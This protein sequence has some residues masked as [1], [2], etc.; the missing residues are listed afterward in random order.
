MLENKHKNSIFLDLD[1]TLICGEPS[2]ELDFNL[3]KNKHKLFDSFDMDGYYMIYS[4]PYLQEFLDYIFSNFNV[5]IWT[6]AS[7]DYALFIIEK[8]ILH[9]KPDRHLDFIFFDYHCNLSKKINNYTKKLSILWDHYKLKNFSYNN[10]IIIDDYIEDVHKCQPNN[11]II[12]TKFEFTKNNSENDTFLKD[13][14]PK[15]KKMKL[16][17]DTPT[18]PDITNKINLELKK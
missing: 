8:I 3:Y 13:I 4:R 16:E 1:H 15:L 14:I 18:I 6:A 9:N 2:E 5:S 11:C 7:K 17:M 10:T 12:A